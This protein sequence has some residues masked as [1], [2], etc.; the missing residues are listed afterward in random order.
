MIASALELA[1]AEATQE[2]ASAVLTAAGDVMT[3]HGNDPYSVA[4]IAA[5]FA[6]AIRQMG[7][8]ID[9]IIPRIVLEMLKESKP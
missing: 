9:P 6:M 8:D 1:A 4:I 7:K 2:I 3:R 5:G